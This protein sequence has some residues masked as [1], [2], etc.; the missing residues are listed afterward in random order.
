MRAKQLLDFP[1]GGNGLG[2]AVAVNQYLVGPI[3]A[4]AQNRHFAQFVLCHPT[5]GEIF[6]GDHERQ[7]VELTLMVGH[8][9]IG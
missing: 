7:D 9:K 5:Q 2:P 1:Q 4:R 6:K 3:H 8:K